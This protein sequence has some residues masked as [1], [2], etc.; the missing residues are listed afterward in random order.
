MPTAGGSHESQAAE[1]EAPQGGRQEEGIPRRN[2]RA[3]ATKAHN[4]VRH[5]YAGRRS[6][7]HS[8]SVSYS[9]ANPSPVGPSCRVSKGRCVQLSR[10]DRLT[11]PGVV[12]MDKSGTT[13]RDEATEPPRKSR[14]PDC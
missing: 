12:P 5:D 4:F 1:T 10:D 13:I 3:D 6:P 8:N 9:N 14:S 7:V 11:V 2:A